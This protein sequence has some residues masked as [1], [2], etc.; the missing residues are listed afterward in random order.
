MNLDAPA[1][2]VHPTQPELPAPAQSVLPPLCW[3]HS[4]QRSFSEAH[5]VR[6]C[7]CPVD[8]WGLKRKEAIFCHVM[9]P[10]DVILG[11]GAQW[12]FCPGVLGKQTD[13]LW[14]AVLFFPAEVKMLYL[15][16]RQRWMLNDRISYYNFLS[17][18][19]SK[20]LYS[21]LF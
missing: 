13:L 7:W 20:D 17:S 2:G 19:K 15:S 21:N 9:Y 14:L 4:Q 16:C 8:C 12:E 1:S 10:E 11:F 5:T 18:H 6:C 3:A